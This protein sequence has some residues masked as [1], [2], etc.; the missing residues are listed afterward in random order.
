METI[1][2]IIAC[3]AFAFSIFTFIFYDHKLKKQEK[4]LNEYQLKKNETEEIE[5]RKAKIRGSI[6]RGEKGKRFLKVYNNG[7]VE[8]SN[9][10]I[11]FLSNL[12]GMFCNC[13]N[14]PYELL[15]PEDSTEILLLLTESCANTIKVKFTWDDNLQC[16]NEFTQ[17]LTL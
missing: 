3:I 1:S 8:A 7:K 5:N 14:F 13:N 16:N 17:V 6:L 9:I 12:N 15:N 11:E 2:F 10:R 4:I